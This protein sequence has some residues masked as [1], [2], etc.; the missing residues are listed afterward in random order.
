[1]TQIAAYQVMIPSLSEFRH[2]PLHAP[3]LSETF[4]LSTPMV[5]F[6]GAP[7]PEKTKPLIACPRTEA[8]VLMGALARLT[9]EGSGEYPTAEA[10]TMLGAIVLSR[11]GFGPFAATEDYPSPFEKM[12]TYLGKT[13]TGLMLDTAIAKRSLD[14]RPILQSLFQAATIAAGRL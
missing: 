3:G 7:E 10:N 8:P 13:K 11:A 9:I 6:D 12:E 1:M 4:L 2:P 14:R 5:V